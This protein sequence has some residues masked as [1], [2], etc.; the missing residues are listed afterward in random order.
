MGTGL[1]TPEHQVKGEG[2][3]GN[4]DLAACWTVATGAHPPPPISPDCSLYRRL[5][6][7]FKPPVVL[8]KGVTSFLNPE[9]VTGSGDAAGIQGQA[10][11]EQL[12]LYRVYFVL[13]IQTE[14]D[15]KY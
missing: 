8:M 6:H 3:T 12:Q 15:C 11:H 14:Q 5:G 13:V 4:L 10:C 2:D 7:V 9:E 1:A